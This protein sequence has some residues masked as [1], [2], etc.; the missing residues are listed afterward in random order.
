VWA[1]TSPQLADQG[2]IY[3]ENCQIAAPA[4]QGSSSGVE[5]YALDS[6]AAE[7]LWVLSEQMAG[8]SFEL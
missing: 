2:G 1:A 4:V 8:Q 5:S 6:A 3:L 7:R